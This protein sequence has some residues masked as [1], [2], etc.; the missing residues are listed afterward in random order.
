MI[1]CTHSL[2]TINIL[3][4][5]EQVIGNV[6]FVLMLIL[7]LEINVIVVD[8][9]ARNK[10]IIKILWLLIILGILMGYLDMDH[11]F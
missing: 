4:N 2:Y 10:M 3:N 6:S 11:A 1:G 8:L 7:P 9:S 5:K